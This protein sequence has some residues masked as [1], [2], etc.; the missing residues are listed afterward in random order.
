MNAMIYS[1][2]NYSEEVKGCTWR[3]V[4]KR[5]KNHKVLP[6]VIK[7]SNHG[8]LVIIYDYLYMSVNN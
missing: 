6:N 7:H 3:K 8:H 1:K 4:F 2:L 5:P